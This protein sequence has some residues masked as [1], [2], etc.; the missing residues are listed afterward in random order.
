MLRWLGNALA[1]SVGKKAVMGLTGLLLVA[2]LVEHLHGNLKLYEAPEEFD[3]YVEWLQ[4]FGWLLVV[5][6][7]G[8]AALFLCHVFLAFRLTLENRQARRQGYVARNNRGA[9]TFGS[10]SM[11]ATGALILAYCLKHLYDFRFDARF[12]EG[13]AERVAATLSQP[14]NALIYVVASILVGVHLSHGFQSAFQSLGVSHPKLVPLLERL[15]VAVAV[16]FAIGFG[17]FPI[18]YMFFWSE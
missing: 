13:P 14:G 4:G 16:L 6:E 7:L 3:G 17:S 9:Q 5:A 11:F 8:L 10:V 12:F 18:Y 15:G 1:S 2:F